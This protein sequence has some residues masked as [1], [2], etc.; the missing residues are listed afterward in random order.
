MRYN[1]LRFPNFKFKAVTLSY[2]DGVVFDEKLIE[3]MSKNELKG[4]FN[5]NSS[6]F[7]KEEGGRRLTKEQAY[8]LYTESGNEVAVHGCVHHS[9]PDVP[10]ATATADI[11][12]DRIALE[13]M[14]G[15]IV[16]G[17]AYAM[18]TFSDKAVEILKNCGIEYART[19]QSTGTFDIPTD[20]LRLKP[21]AHHANPKLME[22]AKSFVEG[23]V[24]NR[25]WGKSPWLFYLWGHSYEFNDANNWNIIEEFAEYVG[26]RDDIWYAT[27]KEIYDYIKAYD[28]LIYSVRM[29]RVKNPSALTVYAN[30]FGREVAIPAGETVKIK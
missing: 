20:W 8:K 13:E 14:F 25:Y 26:N 30:Y 17:M 22:L 21:T 29:D 24:P 27:N 28:S 4:T 7:A 5:I 16:T 1:F 15:T 12:N 10:D 3:I 9:L 6:L 18:G 2:D 23:D 11:V 19:A